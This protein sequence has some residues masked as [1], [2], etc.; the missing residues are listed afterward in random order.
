M[1]TFHKI[2]LVYISITC[3]FLISIIYYYIPSNITIRLLKKWQNKTIIFPQKLQFKV[4][5]HDT[6]NLLNQTS[7]YKIVSHIT[8]Q[9][10]TAC[11]LQLPKWKEIKEA[12][13][14][15]SSEPIPLLLFSNSKNLSKIV[16]ISR[17]YSFDYPICIDEKDS[18][19]IL[20]RFPKDERFHTFLL[21]RNNRVK[22]IGNPVRNS[23]I[24]EL[25]LKVITG[26]TLPK[27]QAAQTTVGYKS[28]VCDLGEFTT[29]ESPKAV[30]SLKNTGTQ[31]L[32]VA[33]VVTSCGCA[34]PRYDKKPVKPGETINITVEMKIKEEG[35]FEKTISVYCNTQNSPLQFKVRGSVNNKKQL[36]LR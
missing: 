9:G 19:N 28:T 30:F 25:Y 20:N 5:N 26:D 29:K 13:D 23:K 27:K 3:I 35:Y 7:K 16:D 11:K 31:P 32:L 22:V 21:D 12:I 8:L 14:S 33:D 36:I 6:I 15:L 34:T 1:K 10:C 18:L 24:K 2:N 4:F 17:N